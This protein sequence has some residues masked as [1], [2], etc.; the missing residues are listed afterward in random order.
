MGEARVA[1]E[2]M[3]DGV[4]AKSNDGIAGVISRATEGSRCN[5]L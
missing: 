1:M 3:R 5:H 4:T 2:A